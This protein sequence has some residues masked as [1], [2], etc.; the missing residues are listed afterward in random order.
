MGDFSKTEASALMNAL[1]FRDAQGNAYGDYCAQNRIVKKIASNYGIVLDLKSS[2]PDVH[3]ENAR[4]VFGA[5][6]M[7]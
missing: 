1:L 3:S 2:H 5:E 7:R 6:T 4:K